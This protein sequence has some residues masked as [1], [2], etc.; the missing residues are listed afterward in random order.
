MEALCRCE[1]HCLSKYLLSCLVL[2]GVVNSTQIP[3]AFYYKSEDSSKVQTL[4]LRGS[5]LLQS[6]FEEKRG[7]RKRRWPAELFQWTQ[8]SRAP[9]TAPPK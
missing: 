4:P 8:K 1:A 3:A 7:C 2:A 5:R 9:L 6:R